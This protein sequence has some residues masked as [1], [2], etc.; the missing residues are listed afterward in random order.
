MC[1]SR[2]SYL[3]CFAARWL[4]LVA[5][6]TFPL[7]RPAQAQQWTTS[8]NDIYNSNGGNVGIGTTSP[9]Y[10]LTVD[11]NILLTGSGPRAIAKDGNQPL[12][13]LSAGG[14]DADN[15]FWRG[16]QFA[17]SSPIAWSGINSWPMLSMYWSYDSASDPSNLTFNYYAGNADSHPYS[18]MF[19]TYGSGNVRFLTSDTERVRIDSSGNVGIG[20]TT[21]SAKLDVAGDVVVSGNISAKYQDIAEWVPSSEQI[22]PGTV[23]ILDSNTPN[24]VVPSVIA[25]DTH[26]AGVV[27]AMPGLI[28]G[29]QGDH[30]VKVA[31]TGRVKVRVDASQSPIR[32]G[33]LLVTSDR[34]G[35]AMRSEPVNLGG[36]EIHRPGTLIGKALEPLS[37]GEGEILVLLSLQ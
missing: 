32:I 18:L 4:L 8:G 9:A 15:P 2:I 14:L 26:V 24:S 25:Y 6:F 11:G 7:G 3:P 35:V 28:L 34:K 31:T 13:L 12:F 20:T 23:V 22:S 36:I 29:E 17:T 16:Y 19:G 30:N 33:D 21:P 5:I 10:K 27:S 37:G 1:H